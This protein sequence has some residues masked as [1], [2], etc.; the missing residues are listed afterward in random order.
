MIYE[1][2][3]DKKEEPSHLIRMWYFTFLLVFPYPLM[4]CLRAL[5]KAI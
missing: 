2:T 5:L 3:T 4:G 1:S